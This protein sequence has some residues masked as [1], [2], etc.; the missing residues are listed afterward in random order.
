[1]KSVSL[2]PAFFAG[3]LTFFSPCVLP[4]IPGYISYITGISFQALTEKN[5]TSFGFI[6]VRVLL[7]V[8]GFT[9]VFTLMG[10]T[11]S[12]IGGFLQTYRRILMIIAGIAISVFG[13]HLI[14]LIK[15]RFLEQEKRAQMKK[16]SSF[17]GPFIMGMAF[18]IGWTPC[19]GPILGSV[20]LVA[21][22]SDS[23]YSGMLLLATYSLGFGLPFLI[24]G[25]SINQFL[26]F[27]KRIKGAFPYIKIASGGILIVFGIL[28][29]LNKLSL[30]IPRV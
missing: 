20:L 7:F 23:V 21:S 25:L 16:R 29:I 9:F 27:F 14:G 28:L 8:L 19:V 11:A 3:V 24:V 15:I 2:L 10:A 12:V 1:M 13:L 4:L 22:V 5:G 6:F 17:I 18:A 30:L 26:K